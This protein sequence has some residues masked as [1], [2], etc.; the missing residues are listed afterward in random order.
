MHRTLRDPIC[1]GAGRCDDTVARPKRHCAEPGGDVE[2][3]LVRSTFGITHSLPFVADKV[4]LLVQVEAIA[5]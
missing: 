2:G 1:S 3:E 5:P 4:R